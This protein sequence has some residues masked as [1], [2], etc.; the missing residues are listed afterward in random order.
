MLPS[1]ACPNGIRFAVGCPAYTRGC[2]ARE[3]TFDEDE[4]EFCAI[5]V[6][7]SRMQDPRRLIA[8]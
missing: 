4:L 6:N 3:N 2:L 7:L 5:R 8:L 1:C